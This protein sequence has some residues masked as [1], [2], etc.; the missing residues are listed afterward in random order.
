[1]KSRNVFNVMKTQNLF[2]SSV[3]KKTFLV[4]NS[5]PLKSN[6]SD[7]AEENIRSVQKHHK[8][9]KIHQLPRISEESD[10]NKTGKLSPQD[11]DED[12][13]VCISAALQWTFHE[14]Q[15]RW[16]FTKQHWANV[17]HHITGW[18]LKSTSLNRMSTLHIIYKKT[19]S[20]PLIYI[21]YHSI[22]SIIQFNK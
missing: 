19:T 11:H 1:M 5:L 2:Y 6:S 3:L 18:F 13:S 16:C 8:L 7:Q 15:P 9:H 20:Q 10:R 17:S 14:R 22:I 12:F 21:Y 4:W